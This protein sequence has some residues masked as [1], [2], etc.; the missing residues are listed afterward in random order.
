LGDY[1]FLFAAM[2]STNVTKLMITN[3]K[4]PQQKLWLF[5]VSNVVNV[6]ISLVSPRTR[7]NKNVGLPNLA[8]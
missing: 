6:D 4:K 8:T 5:S 7:R 2:A 3:T 1:F